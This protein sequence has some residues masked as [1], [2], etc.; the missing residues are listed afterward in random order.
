MLIRA[1]R[2]VFLAV[3]TTLVFGCAST[4]T[5]Q[6]AWYDQSYHGGA[7]RKI[8]V[9]G[10]H[11]DMITKRVFEDAFVASLQSAGVSALS[12]YQVLPP[13]ARFGD[14]A[15]ASAIESSGADG[16]ISVRLLNVDTRTQVSTTLLPAGPAW[17]PY[18]PGWGGWGP[19]WGPYGGPDWGGGFVAVPQVTQYNVAT[20]ETNLWDVKTRRVVYAA[21]TNTI[22]PSSVATETPAF[23]SLII[24]QLQARGLLAAGK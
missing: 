19:Y 14:P 9:V 12:G 6:N 17:G 1:L 11:Q 3:V 24:G 15:W 10:V 5:I 21:T 16:L 7:F 20:V 13:D 2:L 23:A 8:V 22:N 4:T 18:G